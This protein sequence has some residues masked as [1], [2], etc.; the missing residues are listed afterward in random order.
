MGPETLRQASK[1][2][3]AFDFYL[4][5]NFGDALDILRALAEVS[6]DDPVV[7]LLT[8]K[9]LAFIAEPPPPQWNGA[10]ALDSK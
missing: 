6:P 1:Y 9:C 5:R 10:T 2:E 7:A 3:Q 4:H 8:R